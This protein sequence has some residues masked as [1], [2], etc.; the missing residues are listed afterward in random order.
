MVILLLTLI[1]YV[2]VDSTSLWWQWKCGQETDYVCQLVSRPSHHRGRHNGPI[3]QP[4]EVVLREPWADAPLHAMMTT[5]E[6]H[7]S[8]SYVCSP[9]ITC[10]KKKVLCKQCMSVY[11]LQWSIVC[12]IK[13]WK[14]CIQQR[15]HALIE[16]IEGERGPTLWY[17]PVVLLILVDFIWHIIRFFISCIKL[18]TWSDLL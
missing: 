4:V 5:R 9:Y 15:V 8:D 12:G 13:D 3:L 6:S 14:H 16:D 1:L 11:G 18:V 17:L 10:F 2:F 7:P